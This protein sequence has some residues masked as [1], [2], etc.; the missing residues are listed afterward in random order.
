VSKLAVAGKTAAPGTRRSFAV[1]TAGAL[2]ARLA[3][4]A[5]SSD[6]ADAPVLMSVLCFAGISLMHS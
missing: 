1:P 2:L 3:Y 4:Q 5:S 6:T